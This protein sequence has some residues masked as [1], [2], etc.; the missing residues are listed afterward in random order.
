MHPL[1][2]AVSYFTSFILAY[3]EP[4]TANDT[5]NETRAASDELRSMHD[6]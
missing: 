2:T 1:C 4:V 6:C 3:V 5:L